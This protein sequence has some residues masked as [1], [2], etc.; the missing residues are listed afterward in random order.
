MIDGEAL[1][2]GCPERVR[3]LVDLER[4]DDRPDA[5]MGRN[6]GR[7]DGAISTMAARPRKRAG[8]FM[9][10]DKG[11]YPWRHRRGDIVH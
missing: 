2:R 10:P 8:S 11:F 1:P 4:G 6:G 3:C 7:P 9:G 5:S